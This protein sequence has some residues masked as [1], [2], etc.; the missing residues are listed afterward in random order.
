MAGRGRDVTDAELAVLQVLWERSAATIREITEIVYPDD[1]QTQYSTVKRLLARLETK[2]FVERDRNGR[3]HVFAPVGGR[4][5]LL[6][7]RL[8]ALADSL[9]EGSIS[10]LLTHLAKSERLTEGQR[11][12]LLSL[13]SQLAEPVP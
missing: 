2:G 5:E 4:D 1:V 6:G 10:P 13:I 7:R 3:V 11:E 8:E 9:C 12:A